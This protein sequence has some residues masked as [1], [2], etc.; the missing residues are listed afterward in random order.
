MLIAESVCE[1]GV[2]YTGE[3]VLYIDKAFSPKFT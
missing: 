1:K 3:W 2:F